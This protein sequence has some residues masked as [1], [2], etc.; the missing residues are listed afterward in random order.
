MA[1]YAPVA[2][3]HPS[4]LAFYAEHYDVDTPT[5]NKFR[6]IDR[7]RSLQ[8]PMTV[9][10]LKRLESSIEAFRIT[11]SKLQ[12][13]HRGLLA[14]ID[15]FRRTGKS[16][17]VADAGA[18]CSAGTFGE[19]L[20]DEDEVLDPGFADEGAVTTGKLQ[21]RLEDMDL[22][23]WQADLQGDPAIIDDLL[24]EMQKVTPKDE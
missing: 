17:Q 4:R 23:S 20:D 13:N 16:M 9:N 7:E 18:R 11:L 5:G 24:G 10:L 3:I 22:P 19:T 1:V 2:Y 15:E 12:R 8:N 6:Q 14:K 21:T